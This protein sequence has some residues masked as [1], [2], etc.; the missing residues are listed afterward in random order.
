MQEPA[1]PVVFRGS[2]GVAQFSS[3]GQRMLI[4]SGGISNVFDSMRLIDVSSLYRA[5]RQAPETFEDKPAPPWLADISS[6]V[7]AL[8][9]TGDGALLTRKR[10]ERGLRKAKLATRIKQLEAFFYRFPATTND[11]SI[12]VERSTSDI[13]H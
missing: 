6:A 4:L 5:Q 9:P 8:D 7:S 1:E 2:I 13:E 3:D 12:A 10:C 11:R